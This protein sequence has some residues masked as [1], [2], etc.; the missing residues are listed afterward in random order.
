MQTVEVVLGCIQGLPEGAEGFLSPTEAEHYAQLR[1][2]ARRQSYL[3]GRMAAKL[4]LVQQPEFASLRPWDVT[5]A[6]HPSACRSRLDWSATR[7]A[8]RSRRQFGLGH[9]F[10]AGWA[11]L[12]SAPYCSPIASSSESV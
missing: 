8:I 7:V 12:A 6:N 10:S 4:L 9:A 2:A 3:L 5:I 11:V 1:F